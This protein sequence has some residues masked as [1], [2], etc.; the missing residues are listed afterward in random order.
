MAIWD[1]RILM[2][3]LARLNPRTQ[4]ILRFIGY[5][6]FY[7]FCLLFFAKLTFPYDRLKRRIETAFNAA[8]T[9]P[10]PSRLEIEEMSSYWLRGIEAEN[11][12]LTS[13]A[14]L[15]PT[16]DGK[17]PEPNVTNVEHAHASVS[18]LRLLFGTL[19]LSFGADAFA[20]ELSGHYVGSEDER[21]IEVEL[22]D[23]NVGDVPFFVDTVGL[24]LSGQMNGTLEFDLP[25]AKLANANG[26]VEITITA[27]TVG[28]GKAKIRNTIALPQLD[29]GQFE[30]K[31]TAS[32]G[33][34][35]IE[36]FKVE[37]PDLELNADGAIRLRD[38]FEASMADMNLSFKFS[39]RYKNKN[40][41]TRGLFGAPGSSIPGA[42]DLDPKI[43][44]AK[45]T[46]GSYSWRITGTLPNMNFQPSGGG[47][48]PA[49][50]PGRRR[51]PRQRRP[52]P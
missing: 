2:R 43:R 41:V 11:I 17:P 51:T 6:L 8:Q 10:K 50:S 25:E 44:N 16:E 49:R 9:G 20:G 30:L 21:E 7:V 39:D 42:F 29:A 47:A 28:D 33:T 40:D 32:E 46:D 1:P 23:V 26:M 22:S 24:P 14:P 45:Q 3:R 31:A 35:N 18:I 37:G 15:T 4:K 34:L 5:P 13:A 12:S 19:S 52:T 27:F 36:T 38:P 48:A